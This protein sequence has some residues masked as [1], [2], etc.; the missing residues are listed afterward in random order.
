MASRREVGQSAT[1]RAQPG[2][3]CLTTPGWTLF[4]GGPLMVSVG[5]E[6]YSGRV[7]HV[8]LYL[9]LGV[10]TGLNNIS[11]SNNY[12]K[13]GSGV[14]MTHHFLKKMYYRIHQCSFVFGWLTSQDCFHICLF[15]GLIGVHSFFGM[16]LCFVHEPTRIK[17]KQESIHA[18]KLFQQLF[19][20][21]STLTPQLF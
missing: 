12:S 21:A 19:G 13:A 3:A 4:M 18:Q 1:Y 6:K 8:C 2:W 14:S 11:Y 9:F 17:R 5:I 7:A 15:I 10:S 20:G 16:V